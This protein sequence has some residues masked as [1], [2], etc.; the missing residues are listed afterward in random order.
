MEKE[1]SAMWC[2][3]STGRERMSNCLRSA[4]FSVEERAV[5]AENAAVGL[6]EGPEGLGC[7][8]CSRG[9]VV[10]VCV[11]VLVLARRGACLEMPG[12]V[13]GLEAVAIY[14]CVLTGVLEH[15]DKF[16]RPRRYIHGN[17]HEQ[18]TTHLQ[19]R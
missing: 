3:G 13:C 18:A 11:Y 17:G 14:T 8:P 19:H 2:V 16:M 5:L 6:A 1:Q 4:E 10:M 9:V 12:D 7:S 15:G